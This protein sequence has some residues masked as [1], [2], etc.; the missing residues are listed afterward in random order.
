M[1]GCIPLQDVELTN[2]SFTKTFLEG[3]E[4]GVASDFRS[5]VPSVFPCQGRLSLSQCP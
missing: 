4:L 2:A 1:R 3:Q 5:Q